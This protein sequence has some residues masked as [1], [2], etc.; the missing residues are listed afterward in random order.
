MIICLRNKD[1]DE[2]RR[3]GSFWVNDMKN[4]KNFEKKFFKIFGFFHSFDSKVAYS[5]NFIEIFVSKTN[6]HFS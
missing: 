6:A 1:F 2:I 3:I 5:P 4:V